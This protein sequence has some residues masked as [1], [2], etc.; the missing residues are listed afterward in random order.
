MKKIILSCSLLA[1]GAIFLVGCGM[2]KEKAKT[3]FVKNCLLSFPG[4][5]PKDAAETYCNCSADKLLQKYSLVEIMKM[6]EK[7]QKG[8]EAAK[9]EMMKAIQPCVDELAQK[10]KDA[11]Q[12]QGH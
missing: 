11:Q 7:L 5:I 8:D 3:E 1:A 10:A 6:E 2:G 9:A 12:G 4:N